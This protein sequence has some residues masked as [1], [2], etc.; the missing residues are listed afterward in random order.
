MSCFA[1]SSTSITTF[2]DD[3][4]EELTP[5]NDTERRSAEEVL[6]AAIAITADSKLTRFANPLALPSHVRIHRENKTDFLTEADAAFAPQL[7]PKQKP[8]QEDRKAYPSH[9]IRKGGPTRALTKT[10][11]IVVS[12]STA[13][14]IS[15]EVLLCVYPISHRRWSTSPNQE[16]RGL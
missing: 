3:R 14:F 6:L 2:A 13:N 8:K 5:E 12:T 16:F 10:L 7:Q 15:V 4:V 11:S 1:P 9:P